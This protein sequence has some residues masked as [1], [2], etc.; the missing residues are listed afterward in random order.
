MNNMNNVV[1]GGYKYK[2]GGNDARRQ[3]S[4]CRSMGLFH[5]RSM[6]ALRVQLVYE[7]IHVD[8]QIESW[9]TSISLLN[10]SR[11]CRKAFRQSCFSS[12]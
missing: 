9:F 2:S 6:A 11:N 1:N 5:R 4:D 8:V 7:T 10:L 12:H 3:F